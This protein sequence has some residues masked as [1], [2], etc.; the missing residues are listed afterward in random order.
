MF[1]QNFDSVFVKTETGL[2]YKGA[3]SKFTRTWVT[4]FLDIDLFYFA[5]S[6][7]AL[8]TLLFNRKHVA[9]MLYCSFPV[10]W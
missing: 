8:S 5:N 7:V 4:H 10:I 3:T 2:V 9:V 6:M 1:C